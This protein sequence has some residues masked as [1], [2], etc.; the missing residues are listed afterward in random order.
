MRTLTF[1]IIVGVKMQLTFKNLNH[2]LNLCLHTDLFDITKYRNGEHIDLQSPIDCHKNIFDIELGNEKYDGC[3]IRGSNYIDYEMTETYFDRFCHMKTEKE[4]ESFMKLKE[5]SNS[6]VVY[7]IV[8]KMDCGA[9]LE[10]CEN[11]IISNDSVTL[12]KFANNVDTIGNKFIELGFRKGEI[13]VDTI[14]TIC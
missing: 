12:L 1:T 5:L 4:F 11:E 3:C 9:G 10:L 8:H 13:F 14:A 6:I 7:N 2:I